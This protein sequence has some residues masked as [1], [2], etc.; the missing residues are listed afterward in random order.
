M[1]RPNTLHANL[2]TPANCRACHPEHRGADVPLTLFE[3]DLY[4]HS[5]F[6]FFLISHLA[7]PDGR[8]F[9]CQDCHIDPAQP[10]EIE[11]CSECHLQLDAG[12]MRFTSWT[13]V[14]LSRLPRRIESYGSEFD[15]RRPSSGGRI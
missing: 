6:G 9:A 4:P 15:H 5:E 13:S 2:A 3:P 10:F 14:R 7:H 8:A 1:A 12:W 11:T